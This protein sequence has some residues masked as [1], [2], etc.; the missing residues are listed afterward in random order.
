[1]ANLDQEILDNKVASAVNQAVGLLK[2]IGDDVNHPDG[3]M[4][5][6]AITL[7]SGKKTA[8][9]SIV[10]CVHGLADALFEAA[11][12]DE[13]IEAIVRKVSKRLKK[14][15]KNEEDDFFKR[16]QGILPP[17]VLLM[18]KKAKQKTS[19]DD[20]EEKLKRSSNNLL[21][22]LK[23][24]PPDK[25]RKYALVLKNSMFEHD[26]SNPGETMLNHVM[27]NTKGDVP[28]STIELA[29]YVDQ[30]LAEPESPASPIEN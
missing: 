18:M 21:E 14:R 1:M 28:E 5:L 16:M 19:S 6:S 7:E 30:I 4:L 23:A 27:R 15:D 25:K 8:I 9:G 2:S 20:S 29:K 12:E 11:I 26:N 3:V 13:R 10:G 24:M 22:I 17:E